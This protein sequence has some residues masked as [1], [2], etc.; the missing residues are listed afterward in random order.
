MAAH[1]FSLQTSE[2]DDYQE[3]SKR[4]CVCVCLGKVTLQIN[5][6]QKKKTYFL[7]PIISEYFIRAK[8]EPEPISLFLSIIILCLLSTALPPCALMWLC[9]GCECCHVPLFPAK[10]RDSSATQAF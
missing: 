6:Q 9:G 2:S 1:Q 4:V 7:Q 10:L 5:Q 8:P 3:P